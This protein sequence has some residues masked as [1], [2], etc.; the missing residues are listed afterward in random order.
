MELPPVRTQHTTTGI[1]S[2]GSSI[3]SSTQEDTIS[4]A[5]RHRPGNPEDLESIFDTG[6]E[7]LDV[8]GLVI[9]QCLVF[10]PFQTVVK[11]VLIPGRDSEVIK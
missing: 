3:I 9:L 10:V 7:T 6:I 4:A 8:H 2:I 1:S 5:T 11:P